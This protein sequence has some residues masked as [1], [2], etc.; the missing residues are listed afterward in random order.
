MK[1]FIIILIIVFVKKITNIDFSN[2]RVDCICSNISSFS[3]YN[4]KEYELYKEEKIIYDK[5]FN[6]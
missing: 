6:L 1:Y 3:K 2:F 5:I 4:K